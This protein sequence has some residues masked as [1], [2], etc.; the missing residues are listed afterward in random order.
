MNDQIGFIGLGIMGQPMAMNILRAGFPLTV[1]NRTAARCEPLAALGAAVAPTPSA[2]AAR[3]S[4]V[5]TIVTDTPDVEQVL[6]GQ[7]G[8]LAGAPAG[9]LV[10]DMSTISPVATRQLAQTLSEKGLRM[11]DAPVSGGDKG[12]IAGTLS[13]MVGGDE[14]DLVRA[15]PVLEAMGKTITHCGGNGAGQTVKACNQ[16]V[17]ALVIEA[18]SEAL[19]LGAKAGVA[20]RVILEALG[21]GMAQNRVMDLRGATMSRHEFTPGFKARLHRKDLGIVL[22]TARAYGVS[23]PV[24]A[25]VDQMF[26]SLIESGSGEL[27]NSSLITV[28]ERLAG[29]KIGED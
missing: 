18:V 14:D 28:L 9:S 1:Y 21:G 25:L 2:L 17:V 23:L 29:F 4:I 11:L 10:I 7:D 5:I 12:A 8:V 26:G 16:V 19:V 20:P 15:K 13:I 3:S 27:D 6:L 24:T 22:S